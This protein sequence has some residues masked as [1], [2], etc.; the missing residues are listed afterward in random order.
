MPFL[1]R[2]G[3]LATP[4]GNVQTAVV[5]IQSATQRITGGVLLTSTR[6]LK[7]TTATVVVVRTT[8][9][10]LRNPNVIPVSHVIGTGNVIANVIVRLENARRHTSLVLLQLLPQ[11]HILRIIVITAV[12]TTVN[13]V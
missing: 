2:L 13:V 12:V 5:S 9:A 10:K 11:R 6:V 3:K 1:W 4:T 7:T 8:N